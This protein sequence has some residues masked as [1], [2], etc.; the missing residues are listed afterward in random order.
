MANDNSD[1]SPVIDRARDWISLLL[2]APGVALLGLLTGCTGGAEDLEHTFGGGS[3]DARSLAGSDGAQ[4]ESNDGGNGGFPTVGGIGNAGTSG[5]FTLVDWRDINA[6]ETK[7]G[8]AISTEATFTEDGVG[9]VDGFASSDANTT[10][11]VSITYAADETITQIAITTPN[12]TLTWNTG[13]GD[14]IAVGADINASNAGGDLILNMNDAGN[15]SE[16]RFTAYGAWVSGEGTGAGNFGA[17]VGGSPT[18]GAS[19]KI[20]GGATFLGTSYGTF[21]AGDGTIHD[22]SG[23]VLLTADF[24]ARTV[25]MTSFAPTI[26]APDGSLGGDGTNLGFTSNMSWPSQVNNITGTATNVDGDMNGNVTAKF[27]G[28][29]SQEIGGVF[30]LSG[31]GKIYKGAFGAADD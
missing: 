21:V 4:E 7:T 6:P 18:P 5:S 11:S 31:G 17:F 10:S 28:G 25:D 12:R 3:P 23:S 8:I 20:F 13:D 9:K 15:N 24:F 2:I 22:T 26:R 29:N 27:Y 1:F 16:T 30:S 14:T 19:L